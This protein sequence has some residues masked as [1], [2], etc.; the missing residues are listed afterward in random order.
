MYPYNCNSTFRRMWNRLGMASASFGLGL[1]GG[2]SASGTIGL[3]VA[4]SPTLV[5]DVQAWDPKAFQ[6]STSQALDHW[7]E[8][9]VTV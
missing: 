8:L 6:Q 5:H 2:S 4:R 7:T 3:W 1:V 9:L